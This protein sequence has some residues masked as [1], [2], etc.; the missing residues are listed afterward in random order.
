MSEQV[1]TLDDEL[2]EWYEELPEGQQNV[3]DHRVMMA[4]EKATGRDI[5]EEDQ[6]DDDVIALVG[7]VLKDYYLETTTIKLIHAGFIELTGVSPDG[8][9][10]TKITDVGM[11]VL[12]DARIEKEV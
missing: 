2:A 11:E 3:V 9:L 7:K 8:S 1:I 6:D 5:N 12:A 10:M 4:F